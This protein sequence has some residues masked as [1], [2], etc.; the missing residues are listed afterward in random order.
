MV[1]CCATPDGLQRL[2][3]IFEQAEFGFGCA[4]R[5]SES[6]EA[7]SLGWPADLARRARTMRASSGELA[8][9]LWDSSG[10][11]SAPALARAVMGRKSV[12]F[13]LP[14]DL[15]REV[16]GPVVELTRGRAV[17]VDTR[18]RR[19]ALG[20]LADVVERAAAAFAGC[21]AAAV[22]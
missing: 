15:D 13:E 5:W 1:R 14:P 4:E 21:S 8:E 20:R 12:V 19:A 22:A 3:V 2:L 16:P 9:R 17:I 10:R 18:G 6:A 7:E 11:A